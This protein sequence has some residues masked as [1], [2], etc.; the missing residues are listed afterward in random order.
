M[1]L[2]LE[3]DNIE[4]IITTTTAAAATTTTTTT[5]II[6]ITKIF[7]HNPGYDMC[8]IVIL[9]TEYTSLSQCV[10]AVGTAYDSIKNYN[11]YD[12]NGRHFLRLL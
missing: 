8:I 12:T 10:N 9:Y 6:V 11:Y 4:G 7:S 5:T 3:I 2:T 1:F